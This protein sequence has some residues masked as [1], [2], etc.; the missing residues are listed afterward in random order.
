MSLRDLATALLPSWTPAHVH[1]DRGP[2]SEAIAAAI[3]ERQASFT[4]R[5]AL[6]MPPVARAVDLITSIGSTFPLTEYTDGRASA[7]QPRVVRR[8]DPFTSRQEWSEQALHSLIEH[9]ETLWL[10]GSLDDRGYPR[11]ARVL[12]PDEVRVWW[13]ERQVERLYEYKGR[14]LVHGV[15]IRHVAINRRAGE[16]RGR[17]VLRE[18]LPYLATIDAAEAYAAST[19]GSNGIPLTVLESPDAELTKDEADRLKAQWSKSR[20][21]HPHDPAVTSGGVKASFPGISP[22]NMQM[23]ESRAYGATI[24]ARL[25]GIPAPLLHVET[26]GATTV[27]TNEEASIDALVK[28]TIVPRYLHPIESGFGDLVPRTKSVRFDV[29]E[30]LRSDIKTRFEVYTIAKE[31]GVL[32]EDR[33]SAMEGYGR[34][35]VSSE[36]FAPVPQGAAR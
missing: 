24:V 26:S 28:G 10:L 23:Q 4:M 14:R 21:D 13:D 12:P 17:S 30:L 29:N 2:V 5:D 35:D 34:T 8:P 3:S 27:Y 15:D 16:L 18:A 9:G 11:W 36:A 7:D 31:L 25:L 20:Q 1:E 19:F 32:D 6:A 33:I 22:Q